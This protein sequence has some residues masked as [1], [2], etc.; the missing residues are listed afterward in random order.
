WNPIQSRQRE[1]YALLDKGSGDRACYFVHSYY[2]PLGPLSV[3]TCNYGGLE[4]SA[5]VRGKGST[6]HVWGCQFHPEKSGHFGAEILRN[7]LQNAD[8]NNF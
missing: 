1:N 3:A 4:I 6:R 5:V 2:L 7:W 8:A